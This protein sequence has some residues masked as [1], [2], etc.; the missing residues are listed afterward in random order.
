MDGVLTCGARLRKR[1]GVSGHGQKCP[2]PD[3]SRP[4]RGVKRFAEALA[5]LL[6][7]H[8]DERGT[9]CLAKR[10]GA[11]KSRKG[12]EVYCMSKTVVRV[13]GTA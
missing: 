7:P 3:R 13:N 6:L 4:H 10:G 8:R 2:V 9:P 11:D 12:E 5:R 1:R